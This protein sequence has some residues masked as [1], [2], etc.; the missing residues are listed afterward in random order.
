MCKI[1]VGQIT[2]HLANQILEVHFH[3]TTRHKDMY[4]CV[5]DDSTKCINSKYLA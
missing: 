1:N 2:F 3:K 4:S 5:Y